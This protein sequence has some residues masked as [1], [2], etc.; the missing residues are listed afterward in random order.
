MI[1]A[2][3]EDNEDEDN[4][5]NCLG[6][7]YVGEVPGRSHPVYF[8]ALFERFD[9]RYGKQRPFR[10]DFCYHDHKGKHIYPENL[11][12]EILSNLVLRNRIMSPDYREALDFAVGVVNDM[13]QFIVEGDEKNA[14]DPRILTQAANGVG[15]PDRPSKKDMADAVF[16]GTYRAMARFREPID[17]A[18]LEKVHRFRQ[19]G[20]EWKRIIHQ[21][22][23]PD[24]NIEDIADIDSEVSRIQKQYYAAY[25]KSA[26]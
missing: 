2:P 16:D 6:A 15:V 12:E 8:K 21:V 1:F 11:T 5:P 17:E 18:E 10:M 9:A 3:Y 20:W 7:V 13:R 23:Y 22:Y 26:R 4:Y 14:D 24:E 25:P 19:D